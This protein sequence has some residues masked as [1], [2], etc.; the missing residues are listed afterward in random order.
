MRFWNGYMVMTSM[1]RYLNAISALALVGCL[2]FMPEVHAQKAKGQKETKKAA[3]KSKAEKPA[4]GKEPIE[5]EQQIRDI[6]AFLQYVLNSIGSS[7]TP[8]RDKDVLITESYSKIFVDS[9]VQVED[10]LDDKR[11]TI[12]NKDIVAY[13]K[14]VDF[15][16]KDVKFEFV[17]ENIGK[18]T[19]TSG[20]VFYKVSLT[21][22]L[23]GTTADGKPVNNTMPRF[24]EINFNPQD[25]DLK[26]ASIYTNEFNE[27]ETLTNWWKNLSFGWKDL[28]TRKLAL[29]DSVGFEDIKNITAIE[30]LDLSG[31][32]Y[33][34]NI[35]PL[36]QLTSLKLLD[37]S[38]TAIGDLT[39]IRNLTELLEVNLS[40]SKVQDLVS[41]KYS[42]KLLRLNIN[43]TRVSDISVIEKMTALQNLEMQRTPVVDFTPLTGLKTLLHLDVQG[44][45]LADLTVL[46]GLVDL[47]ELNLSRTL[48]HELVP[49]KGLKA[50]SVLNIDSTAVT[51]VHALAFIKTLKELKANYTFISSLDPLMDLP[52][53]EKIYCDQ[54][55]VTGKKLEAFK[56]AKPGVLVVFDS[57]DLKAWWETLSVDWQ[58]IFSKA[59]GI[60]L[61]PTKEELATIGNIDSINFSGRYNISSLDPLNRLQKLTVVIGNKTGIKD[62]TPLAGHEGIRVLDISETQVTD[63]SPLS[64]L[65]KLRILKADKTPVEKIDPL[66]GLE[67]LEKIYVDHTSIHDITALELLEKNPACLVV[68]KTVHLNRWWNN[69]DDSWRAAL[70]EQM[71]KDTASTR[72]NLHRLVERKTLKIN[73]APVNDLSVLNEFVQLKDLR[74]SAT[75][76]TTI[77][78]LDN[79]RHLRLLHVTN[80]PLSNI[81]A[82]TDLKHLE[83][84]DISNTPVDDLGPIANLQK[85][86]ALNCSGTQ[87]RKLD[88]LEVLNE[89][90][91]LDCSNTRIAQLDRIFHLP[92]KTLK[93]YNTK[94]TAKEVDKFKKAN[95]YCNV[96]YYR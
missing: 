66:F 83:D 11:T 73:E 23:S 69:L 33:I 52:A 1:R 42:S 15:F 9:K 7:E 77:P 5:G 25:Q 95:P 81:S 3:E 30:D 18:S 70:Q 63:L 88:V 71:G 17:T 36:A 16:F 61:A 38:E 8:A 13:L 84:L 92:L 32:A 67:A 94:V 41:L 76:I 44:T 10:D 22:N 49:L 60:G 89:I 6:I 57:K 96:I 79:I 28:F 26:I 2:C 87:I 29:A 50:L 93:C 27:K 85:L 45:G 54:T 72:E 48:I 35:E 24:I 20:Q 58:K 34:Q 19:T 74:L 90:E 82:L 51:D 62:L 4:A 55:S 86:K 31:N 14:D 21:R 53:L 59:A 65:S 56:A 12:T 43:R 39:P 80:S 37:L 91:T 46:S 47:Y 40:G 68:Y 75:Q 64:R 78:P